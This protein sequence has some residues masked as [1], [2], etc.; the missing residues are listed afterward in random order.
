[1]ASYNYS[2][3]VNTAKVEM[4]SV[5]NDMTSS[6]GENQIY[7][8]IGDPSQ[9]PTQNAGTAAPS[10]PATALASHQYDVVF[11]V[12][13]SGGDYQLTQCEAYGTH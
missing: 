10:V 11:G 13:K 1:M 7:A 9:S 8:Q 6:I 4:D 5:K 2:I 12:P 3:P